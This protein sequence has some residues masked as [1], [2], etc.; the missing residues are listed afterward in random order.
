MENSNFVVR[1]PEPCHE[2]WNKMK[3]EE[4][5]RFCNSCSKIVVD[6]SNK[7]DFEIKKVLDENPKGHVCGHFKKS[8]LDRPLNYTIDLKNL[9]RNIS[10]TK[11]FAIALFLV[12]GSI[13]FSC[14]DQ[15]DQNLVVGV[16]EPPP[17]EIVTIGEPTTT[18]QPLDL[19]DGLIETNTVEGNIECRTES[20]VNGGVG[21]DQIEVIKDSI[22]GEEV[23]VVG[24]SIPE[25]YEER[26]MGAMVMQIVYSD[27]TV[28]PSDSTTQKIQIGDN[29]ISKKTDLSIY[30]NPTTGDFIIKYDVTKRADI[31][32]DIYDLKGAF[33]KAVVDQP[34]QYEGKYQIPVNLNEMPAGIYIVNLTNGEKRFTEKVVISK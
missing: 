10:T 22:V 7:T 20:F 17:Q 8:Q 28:T 16:I 12:F 32:I 33:V 2:D 24:K 18:V 34:S 1:V 26:M 21:Y 6:F 13:L 4:K 30:P 25:E 23:E 5:G 9:P 14:T 3:P 19:I 27:P 15:K 31:K 29:V 11:A